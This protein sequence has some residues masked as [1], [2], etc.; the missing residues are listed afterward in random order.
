ML[1][2]YYCVNFTCIKIVL[3]KN[4]LC[5]KF[6]IWSID[7]Q[8]IACLFEEL[9]EHLRLFLLTS[10]SFTS[11]SSRKSTNK[12]N[13]IPPF[14]MSKCM[15]ENNTRNRWYGESSTHKNIL[16]SVALNLTFVHDRISRLTKYIKCVT[17]KDPICT[18]LWEIFNS[19]LESNQLNTCYCA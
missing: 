7:V 6:L 2:Y 13:S 8:P 12:L 9:K 18:L 19:H 11:S 4:V 10:L 1:L 16:S 17:I 5:L 14:Q 3:F 15:M